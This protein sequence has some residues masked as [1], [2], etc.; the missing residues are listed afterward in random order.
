M[1]FTARLLLILI[2]A[3]FGSRGYA[4]G[5]K[6]A[7]VRSPDRSVETLTYLTQVQLKGLIDLELLKTASAKLSESPDPNVTTGFVDDLF[8]Q[9]LAASSP[10]HSLAKRTLFLLIEDSNVSK[11]RVLQWIAETVAAQDRQNEERQEAKR[12]TAKMPMV[13]ATTAIEKA[14]PSLLVQVANG[15]FSPARLA[16]LESLIKRVLN[17]DKK[18]VLEAHDFFKKMKPLSDDELTLAYFILQ[19]DEDDAT[20]AL[21]DSIDSFL[22]KLETKESNKLR[23]TR[24]LVRESVDQAARLT[25]IVKLM[26][27]AGSPGVKQHLATT[28]FTRKYSALWMDSLLELVNAGQALANWFVIVTALHAN[29][30]AYSKEIFDSLISNSDDIQLAQFVKNALNHHENRIW[31]K[32]VFVETLKKAGPL[33]FA[34][35]SEN[36][37]GN[38]RLWNAESLQ[39]FMENKV[40]EF[41]DLG[42][43]KLTKFVLLQIPKEE[44]SKWFRQTNLTSLRKWISFSLEAKAN[45]ENDLWGIDRPFTP[46]Q[47]AT[48]YRLLVQSRTKAELQS[49]L[50]EFHITDGP[51]A[52][53]FLGILQAEL[54]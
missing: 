7:V 20:Y 21:A 4:T 47:R 26:V 45:D 35:I 17:P 28:I 34:A 51:S 49:F 2:T 23:E 3:L 39:L 11:D 30:D 46:S 37:T 9:Q 15:L 24:T 1:A 22:K 18:L 52:R 53:S 14:P 38:P 27:N 32:E 12:E 6:S 48:L 50:N 29:H 31:I 8:P 13:L 25:E 43:K 44:L 36:A 40:F 16:P 33:T 10:T 5:C 41:D 19:R 42:L 54:K